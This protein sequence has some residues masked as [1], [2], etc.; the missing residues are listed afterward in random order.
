MQKIFVKSAMILIF[1]LIVFSSLFGCAGFKEKLSWD[2][3]DENLTLNERYTSLGYTHLDGL[4]YSTGSSIIYA[5][6]EFD[7]DPET[8]EIIGV[9][10]SKDKNYVYKQGSIVEGADPS[11]FDIITEHVP[12]SN[13][14]GFS[15]SY[16]RDKDSVFYNTKRIDGADPNTLE[17]LAWKYSR[18][19][20]NVFKE[21][22]IIDG[23][24]RDSFDV[25]FNYW[26]KD[27][28]R[29]YCFNGIVEGADSDTFEMIN[30]DWWKDKNSVYK[31]TSC[32]KL[33]GVDPS[34]FNPEEYRKQN[35]QF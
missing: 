23:A 27:K 4:Y 35:N 21:H 11:T 22:Q 9:V 28:N 15:V 16:A 8:F 33:E 30:F 24:D 19:K 34:L 32:Q 12:D 29:V 1:Q 3:E 18:D 7:A 6:H 25:L 10:Y 2:N 31:F 26:A 14:L 17:P 13:L 5:D 20:N